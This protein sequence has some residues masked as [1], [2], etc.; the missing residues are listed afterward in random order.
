M[1]TC[2]NL[3][4][5]SKCSQFFFK[6]LSPICLEDSCILR[7]IF[8]LVISQIHYH[9]SKLAYNGYGLIKPTNFVKKCY[10]LQ[11]WP[12]YEHLRF[13]S[14]QGCNTQDDIKYYSLRENGK[15]ICKKWE[16]PTADL[17]WNILL[18]TNIWHGLQTLHYHQLYWN[19]YSNNISKTFTYS[20]FST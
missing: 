20:N 11:P 13:L 16:I 19:Y 1:I 9:S 5:I 10:K 7:L 3:E 12:Y 2:G 4:R 14:Y 8:N 18:L 15:N 6:V 17:C